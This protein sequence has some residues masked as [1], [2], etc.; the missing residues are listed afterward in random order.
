MNAPP[1]HRLH[2]CQPCAHTEPT[3]V[4]VHELLLLAE[5]RD[6]LKEE[7]E[8]DLQLQRAS[9]QGGEADAEPPKLP[10]VRSSIECIT[11]HMSL[12][13]GT[14]GA[15]YPPLEIERGA[16][17]R[18]HVM[19]CSN[20]HLVHKECI[21]RQL[22]VANDDRC[23][24]CRQTMFRDLDLNLYPKS[25]TDRVQQ[26][27]WKYVE[28]KKPD[29]V[30]YLLALGASPNAFRTVGGYNALHLAAQ[31]GNYGVARALLDDPRT[32]LRTV[33]GT[34]QLRADRIALD[35]RGEDDP[36]Y[37]LLAQELAKV[38]RGERFEGEPSPI[39][40]GPDARSL[41][42]QLKKEYMRSM[43]W[44]KH[45]PPA[46]ASDIGQG[47][48]L[49][50]PFES[51]GVSLDLRRT[52]WDAAA[53]NWREFAENYIAGGWA[54]RDVWEFCL[55]T[56]IV[57]EVALVAL[58]SPVASY[59]EK[60][61]Y[62]V[63]FLDAIFNPSLNTEMVARTA[64]VRPSQ[65]IQM[66]GLVMRHGWYYYR[67]LSAAGDESTPA[68][69][70]TAAA[71]SR[72]LY[73]WRRPEPPAAE[74]D[75]ELDEI[76]E[77]EGTMPTEEERRQEEESRPPDS[78]EEEEEGLWW[79]RRRWRRWQEEQWRRWQ[80]EEPRGRA[81]AQAPAIRILPLPVP[82]PA[83]PV[84]QQGAP[85]SDESM[86]DAIWR[87]LERLLVTADP[88]DV[89]ENDMMRV[90]RVGPIDHFRTSD[91]LPGMTLLMMAAMHGYTR[92]MKMM[93]LSFNAYVPG[94]PP[95]EGSWW[96]DVTWRPTRTRLINTAVAPAEGETMWK[97]ALWY[98]LAHGKFES[99]TVLLHLGAEVQNDGPEQPWDL[100]AQAR[101]LGYPEDV[102]GEQGGGA[103]RYLRLWAEG[104]ENITEPN[105][106]MSLLEQGAS[107]ASFAMMRYAIEQGARVVV[108]PP[109]LR[110]RTSSGD[111]ERIPNK[112]DKNV[113]MTAILFG[114]DEVVGFLI[115]EVIRH[116][117]DDVFEL[118][119]PDAMG[120]TPMHIAAA[121]GD[122]RIVERVLRYTDSFYQENALGL[123]PYQ[124][125]RRWGH[126]QVAERILRAIYPRPETPFT[127]F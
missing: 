124:L 20:E 11:C 24:E 69:A 47:V 31:Y 74:A 48:T 57:M 86:A 84:E 93:L 49:Y 68:A 82:L 98:A 30:R 27:L 77:E 125:A 14:D 72:A 1:L 120:N 90:L 118:F 99:A 59:E 66:W 25:D 115:D 100:I 109:V 44:R 83:G 126:D 73:V 108:P 97:T 41:T 13:K 79:W 18:P 71:Q 46:A 33:G 92:L 7:A 80:E 17:G 15:P 32:N 119:T 45:P 52:S 28:E 96:H 102:A 122:L 101:E 91:R 111:I 9:L 65:T 62:A 113:L 123:T 89:D 70:R 60:L 117:A 64:E 116:P 40:A 76:I 6:R 61:G 105:V 110:R 21:K 95:A 106:A 78:D 63:R 8:L 67:A 81:P 58:Q 42:L 43:V 39:P 121:S 3:D 94:I 112:E 36:V 127:G 26:D 107:I 19:V 10:K 103:L 2:L 56:V 12:L 16:Y 22:E 75:E 34:L 53:R 23:P 51:R 50:D 5:E 85:G 37:N 29:A 4:T 35:E 87:E 38:N 114:H 88:P 54:D 55:E 104:M